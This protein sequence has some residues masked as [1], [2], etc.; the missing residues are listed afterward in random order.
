M[1]KE[2]IIVVHL[3]RD[4]KIT[5]EELDSKITEIKEL[6]RASKS[7]VVSTVI[8]NSEKIDAK[9]YIGLE[10]HKKFVN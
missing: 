7:E 9:F 10:R 1:F 8:Q 6:V 2:K 4:S 3:N 5:Q